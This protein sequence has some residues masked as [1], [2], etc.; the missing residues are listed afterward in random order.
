MIDKE[1]AVLAIVC[2]TIT[3]VSIVAG[4]WFASRGSGNKEVQLWCILDTPSIMCKEFDPRSSGS[5]SDCVNQSTG[6]NISTIQ[7]PSN[8]VLCKEMENVGM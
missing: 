7:R 6:T 1:S 8:V 2:G 3:V 4:L 5:L